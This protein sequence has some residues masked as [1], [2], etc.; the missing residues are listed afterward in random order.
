MSI[1]I[2]QFITPPPQAPPPLSLF[3]VLP[4]EGE[5]VLLIEVAAV[6]TIE[7]YERGVQV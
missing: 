5:K 1:P 2:A 4:E 3:G 7:D 6:T